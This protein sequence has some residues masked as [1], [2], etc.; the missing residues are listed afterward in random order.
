MGYYN[1]VSECI[2]DFTTVFVNCYVYNDEKDYVVKLAK[3]L[4]KWFHVKM[5]DMP[6]EEKVLYQQQKSKQLSDGEDEESDEL[7][8]DRLPSKKSG[9][10]TKNVAEQKKKK[11]NKY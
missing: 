3:E 10:F 11:K 5:A 2:Y 1:D 7:D 8:M 6:K 4:E 9:G